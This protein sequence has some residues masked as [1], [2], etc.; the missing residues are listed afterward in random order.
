MMRLLFVIVVL[1]LESLGQAGGIKIPKEH[2]EYI[3]S[4]VQEFMD[5]GGIIFCSVHV[6]SIFHSITI[7]K[8]VVM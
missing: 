4:L 6:L 8:I 1:L 3:R 5:S 2:S 7:T